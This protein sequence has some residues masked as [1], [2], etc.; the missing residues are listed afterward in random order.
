MSTKI[1]R[2]KLLIVEGRDEEMFFDAALRDHLGLTDIQILP[3]GG[4]TK[5]TQNLSGLVNDLDF[6]TV[7]SLAILRDADLTAPGAAVASAAQAFQSVCG[8]LRHVN[9]PCPAAHR[10]FAIGS[11]RVA[12][13]RNFLS[14]LIAIGVEP[15][16][17]VMPGIVTLSTGVSW[18]FC[19]S[20]CR[21]WISLLSVQPT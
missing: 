20:S 12:A 3:I 6:V 5:L 1:V 10:Q 4:K 11:P 7:Q 18:P 13:N 9:L 15:A 8:S 19:A 17:L 14:G 16:V 2:S 21:T